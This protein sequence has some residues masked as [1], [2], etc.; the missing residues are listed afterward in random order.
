MER[1][2]S[3]EMSQLDKLY[4]ITDHVEIKVGR[5]KDDSV[6]WE[7]HIITDI[8]I[9][10]IQVDAEK[11]ENQGVFRAQYLKKLHT[12]APLVKSKEWLN[13]LQVMREDA[14]NRK[15]I[16]QNPEE[17]E[18]VYIARQVFDEICSFEPTEDGN[19]VV[20]KQS[21][22]VFPHLGYHCVPSTRIEE[23]VQQR[24]YKIAQNTLSKTMTELGMKA[25]G[26][27]VV[28]IVTGQ[29]SYRCWWFDPIE[30][31][32]YKEGEL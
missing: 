31:A 9:I 10:I 27:K 18:N 4:A 13:F 15:A 29:K 32:R 28:R 21:R 12:P 5:V 11:L 20:K 8:E 23:I 16:S 17:S 25:P 19:I 14:R 24:G 3:E 26:T 7:F 22:K 1:P 2:A 30:I 6:I